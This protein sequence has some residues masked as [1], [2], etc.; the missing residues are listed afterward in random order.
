MF[1][2]SGK[3]NRI[4]DE[5]LVPHPLSD[6]YDEDFVN[7][8]L[9]EQDELRE[10][11]SEA[12]EK[13]K[14]E[15]I[16]E[17][18]RK[19]QAAREAMEEF[20][21][22]G[23]MSNTRGPPSGANT[24]S[25][26]GVVSGKKEEEDDAGEEIVDEPKPKRARRRE[27]DGRAG[28]GQAV[29]GQEENLKTMMRELRRGVV[30][31]GAAEQLLSAMQKEVL[32]LSDTGGKGEGASAGAAG[33]ASGAVEMRGSTR[34]EIGGPNKMKS[35]VWEG[36]VDF[37]HEIEWDFLCKPDAIQQELMECYLP[38]E[39]H[40]VTMIDG[41]QQFQT[42][43]GRRGLPKSAQESVFSNNLGYWR[44]P[45]AADIVSELLPF[46][47]SFIF[48]EVDAFPGPALAAEW[49]DSWTTTSG[50]LRQT[51]TALVRFVQK[52]GGRV[53]VIVCRKTIAPNFLSD[54]AEKLWKSATC[55]ELPG[56][57]DVYGTRLGLYVVGWDEE[58]EIAEGGKLVAQMEKF[59]DVDF[60]EDCGEF[61]DWF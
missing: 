12:D 26:R 4:K 57:D 27:A 46:L 42:T 44:D 2:S 10:Q 9:E 29:A 30:T 45:I 58:G 32:S 15:Q 36:D 40:C 51:Q 60:P 3:S 22:L 41:R 16:A 59:V 50:P 21:S 34:G 35:D 13:K 33:G 39:P 61:D 14:K 31:G 5:D 38:V 24:D 23:G 48:S 20:G 53:S 1:G 47:P 52:H 56:G 19:V 25:G 18:E 28:A 11:E 43:G 8:I 6:D 54:N 49:A 37:V 55:P 7:K 17:W